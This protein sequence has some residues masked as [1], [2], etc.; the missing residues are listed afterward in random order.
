MLSAL[1]DTLPRDG[2]VDTPSGRTGEHH[3]R[4][5]ATEE[6]NLDQ[7][8]AHKQAVQSVH[9]P[10][11]IYDCEVPQGSTDYQNYDKLG[12]GGRLESTL[13]MSDL[14]SH[15]IDLLDDDMLNERAVPFWPWWDAD[16]SGDSSSKLQVVRQSIRDGIIA[17]ILSYLRT[18]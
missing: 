14:L 15:P 2:S 3:D 17:I 7:R 4:A 5:T 18:L 6:I 16:N 1:S 10:M 8:Q 11:S 12:L 9:N 13:M